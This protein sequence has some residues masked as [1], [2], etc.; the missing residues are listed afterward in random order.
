MAVQSHIMPEKIQE[1]VSK[2]MNGAVLVLFLDQMEELF[3]A[4][5]NELANKFLTVLY[6]A[7]QKGALRVLA[8]IR[9]DHLHHCHAHPE[10]LRILRGPGH[11]PIGPVEPFMLSDTGFWRTFGLVGMANLNISLQACNYLDVFLIQKLR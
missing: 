3:T 10:I 2:G 6:E 4:Q 11:Y 1:M 8:T 9:S 5:T 7:A